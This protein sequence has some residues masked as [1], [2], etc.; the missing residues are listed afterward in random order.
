LDI[1]KD[2]LLAAKEL[3]VRE[4]TTAGRII[5]DL[6][7]K[8]LAGTKTET[9]IRNGIPVVA[10]RGEVITNEHVRRLMDEESV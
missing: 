4:K 7:R 2:V 10:S 1:E 8:G 9:T 3:A 6:A 5:S